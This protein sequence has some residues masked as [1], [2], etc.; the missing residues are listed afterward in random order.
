MLILKNS[1]KNDIYIINNLVQN[2]SIKNNFFF[3]GRLLLIFIFH[4]YEFD[5]VKINN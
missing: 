5:I 3:A 1:F 4:Y 2:S